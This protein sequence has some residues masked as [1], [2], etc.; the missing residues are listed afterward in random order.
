MFDF[1]DQ[2][3][4]ISGAAGSLGQAAARAF[5]ASGA[6]LVLTDYQEDRL[7]PLY[8]DIALSHCLISSID[9]TDAEDV[10]R[11]VEQAVARFGCVDIVLNIA[12]GF[13]TSYIVH[14]KATETWDYMFN[15]N[16]RSAFLVSRAV[17]P[18][19]IRKGSGKIVNVSSRSGL[20]GGANTA[21][22]AA[23][24]SAVIR[25]TESM[26]AELKDKGIYVNCI[27]PGTIDTPD[28][29]ADM[30]NADFSKWVEPKAIADVMRFLVSDL[31]RGINGAIIPVYGRG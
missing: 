7:S 4:L 10:D 2:V 22:Y 17:A 6:R 24:K 1:S 27:L 18:H 30:S 8:Q 28:N 16:A 21:A 26:A 14:E 12:G 5:H 11:L 3:V 19:M 29:R 13:E 20:K 31:A 25:L 23:S 15:L 9:I